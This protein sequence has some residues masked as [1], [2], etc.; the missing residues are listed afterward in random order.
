TRFNL[1]GE[2]PPVRDA[3]GH[4]EFAGRAVKI[5]LA[6]G[7]AFMESGRSVAGKKGTLQLEVV[8]G[9]P[10]LGALEIDVEGEAAAV[11]ELASYQ[12]IDALRFVDLAPEDFTGR[13]T[14]HVS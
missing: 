8:K 11:T 12:P 9:E 13:V 1:T 2:L 4:V 10:L 5:G 7:T 14:G 3:T 6:S